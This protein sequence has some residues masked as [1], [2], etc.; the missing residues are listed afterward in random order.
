MNCLIETLSLVNRPLRPQMNYRV[1]CADVLTT[2]QQ[3]ISFPGR[4]TN[5][6]PTFYFLWRLTQDRMLFDRILIL[7]SHQCIENRQEALD[8]QTTYEYYFRS[9]SLFLERLADDDEW[10]CT[11]LKTRY[12]GSAEAYLSEVIVPVLIPERMDPKE[13]KDIS[14]AIFD[15][16]GSE[17]TVNLYFDFTGGSRLAS[18]IS[19][20]LM[21]I[22]ETRDAKVC[23]VIY[24][25]IQDPKDPKI[26]DCTSSYEILS[27]IE[28]I[29][30]AKESEKG[31]LAK[32]EEV[33]MN[34]GLATA[35]DVAEAKR[36]DALA[37]GAAQ[38]LHVRSN[39]AI[40]QDLNKARIGSD[41]GT[42]V[43]QKRGTRLRM[44]ETR[45]LMMANPF[46]K[47]LEMRTDDLIMYFH[48]QIYLVLFEYHV[49]V[50][51]RYGEG[52][53]AK[54]KISSIL[55]ANDSYYCDAFYDK[56]SGERQY[57]WGVI[58]QTHCWINTLLS[59]P[60]FRPIKTFERGLRVDL[61]E[62]IATM[63]MRFS[64]YRSK[65]IS[66]RQIE[67]FL[68]YLQSMRINTAGCPYDKTSL[69]Q[70]VYFNYGFPFKCLDGLSRDYPMIEKRYRDSVRD[71]MERLNS[72]YSQNLDSYRQELERLDSE[73][74]AL[75]AEIPYLI[76]LGDDCALN[77]GKFVDSETADDF[78]KTLC[79]RIE[80]V[81][82]Y[83][84][85]IAHH[86]NNGY[87][88]P[89]KKEK[90]A[91]QICGWVREYENFLPRPW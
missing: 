57:S 82:P 27:A 49:F 66:I 79:A 36:F 56:I 72:L 4:Q 76:D 75:E 63:R 87:S 54:E 3:E 73:P 42:S 28:R 59:N 38:N 48:E 55:K 12:C 52:D 15:S 5:E 22:L 86:L 83:R 60:Q 68:R 14:T 18:M 67:G 74:G 37:E 7:V 85:A 45:S 25:D 64:T 32:I 2:E 46:Q 9:T 6:A 41:D 81:R 51:R 40:E 70:V 26:I 84:N 50:S 24:G 91:E 65:G 13:W 89:E 16:V 30:G 62:Y 8:G 77:W 47:L 71:L 90:I 21:R 53:R 11:E 58:P 34:Y 39:S 88:V 35:E 80:E 44:V 29:A 78:V 31:K 17:E 69:W 10:L 43:V 1:S 23:R 33:L 19:L 61:P 20:L